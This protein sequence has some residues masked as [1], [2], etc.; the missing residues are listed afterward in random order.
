MG[1]RRLLAGLG[2]S[3]LIMGGTLVAGAP[4]AS[5]ISVD[6]FVN[7]CLENNYAAPAGTVFAVDT[8]D[9]SSSPIDWNNPVGGANANSSV[10]DSNAPTIYITIG[11]G[12]G[13]IEL[14]TDLGDPY[15][16]VC[17]GSREGWNY[18]LIDKC[19]ADSTPIPPW[20]Q[21]YG[22]GMATDA[23]LDGW[24][25]SWELWPHGGTGG[26]VCTREIPSLG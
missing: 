11:D 5:A 8:A 24:T 15:F 20:V 1:V 7:G 16:G 13:W 12:P 2:A 3:A 26:W 10:D 25:A 14:L 9:C 23:C 4:A 18:D 21:G 19:P 17:G 22:R 6:Y